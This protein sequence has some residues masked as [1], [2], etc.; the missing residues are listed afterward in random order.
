MQVGEMF[1]TEAKAVSCFESWYWP[2]GEI[3]CLRCGSTNVYRVE[4]GRPMPYRC[5]DCRK[6]FSLK[7]GTAMGKSPLPLRLW[8]WAIYLELTSLRVSPP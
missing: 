7:K 4:S 1:A 5:R 2:D 8:G 6:Y 3:A